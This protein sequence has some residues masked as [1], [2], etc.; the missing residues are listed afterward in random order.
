M[1]EPQRHRPSDALLERVRLRLA[2]DQDAVD[3]A[4]VFHHAIMRGAAGHYDLDQR[5][6]WACALPRDPGAWVMRQLR[7]RTLV[8]DL[9][10]RCVGFCELDL[11]HGR[12]SMLYVWPSLQ[13]RGIGACLLAAALDQARAEKLAHLDI[14][15]SLVLAPRLERLGWRRLS[16]ERV[17]RGG[18]V[19]ERLRYRYTLGHAGFDQT[20]STDRS[21][22]MVASR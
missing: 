10:R 16:S 1:I 7:Y 2:R 17:E 18:V 5:E 20:P 21:Q 19:L 15:A 4:E 11:P 8:A 9:D 13:G 3:Q 14:D 12:I 6:A 22:R